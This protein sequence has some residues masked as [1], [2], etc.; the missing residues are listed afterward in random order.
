MKT[1]AVS[2]SAHLR[3]D[4][5]LLNR[6]MLAGC[7]LHAGPLQLSISQELAVLL[8]LSLT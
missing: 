3:T 8:L 4:A 2:Q 6:G 1:S 7:P 5:V